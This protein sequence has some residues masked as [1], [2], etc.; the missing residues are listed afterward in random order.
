MGT[1]FLYVLEVYLT[2]NETLGAADQA[3]EEPQSETDQ[4]RKIPN[5]V[6]R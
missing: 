2:W 3:A 6:T 5:D 4:L 1:F